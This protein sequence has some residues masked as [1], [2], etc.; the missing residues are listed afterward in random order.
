MASP[1]LKK[2]E[3][4]ASNYLA[5]KHSES[6]FTLLKTA[7]PYE[8]FMDKQSPRVPAPIPTPEVQLAD[9]IVTDGN[10][11]ANSEG[12]LEFYPDLYRG[13]GR[14]AGISQPV[15]QSWEGL[16]VFASSS[17]GGVALAT[18]GGLETQPSQ[19]RSL[20]SAPDA[21][22]HWS[23]SAWTG[24]FRVTILGQSTPD[25]VSFSLEGYNGAWVGLSTAT[26]AYGIV[27][28]ISVAVSYSKLRV[29]AHTPS[30]VP[31]HV[32]ARVIF[33][34]NS[35]NVTFENHWS[36]LTV[37]PFPFLIDLPEVQSF[38]RIAGD[39]LVTYTGSEL[40]NGGKIASALVPFNWAPSSGTAFDSVAQLRNERY[41]GPLK[42]G[43]HVSWRPHD[44]DDLLAM[45]FDGWKEP[46]TKIVVGY[47]FDSADASVR[48]RCCALQGIYSTNPIVGQMHYSPPMTDEM[49]EALFHYYE[50]TPAATENKMHVSLKSVKNMGNKALNLTK[51]MLNHDAMISAALLAVGQPELAAAVKLAGSVVRKQNT[52]KKKPS[53]GQTQQKVPLNKKKK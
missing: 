51:A 42:R 7:L 23:T 24:T 32:S 41:D 30:G 9:I 4:A 40:V 33:E 37:L 21:Y 17:A 35:G 2:E 53:A 39:T 46:S 36:N 48:I 6:G 25:V 31:M 8:N 14:T 26:P 45:K 18:Y 19:F 29:V 34:V 43:T 44:L 12:Y 22:F 49:I 28:S 10:V 52:Q 5:Q 15:G 1:V 20:V 13:L 50:N 38:R 27:G 11:D 3:A 16:M 47:S